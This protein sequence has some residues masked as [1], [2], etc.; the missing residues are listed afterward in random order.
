MKKIAV[1]VKSSFGNYLKENN[2]GDIKEEYREEM[3]EVM[4][5]LKVKTSVFLKKLRNEN[6]NP[7]VEL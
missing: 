7:K 4:F 2:M 3:Q 6:K 1:L 5:E